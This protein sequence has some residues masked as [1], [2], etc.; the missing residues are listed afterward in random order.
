MP[1]I[2]ILSWRPTTISMLSPVSYSVGQTC[3]QLGALLSTLRER[4]AEDQ[5]ISAS[6][7]ARLLH[8]SLPWLLLIIL[9]Q[10]GQ[11][12]IVLIK[13]LSKCLFNNASRKSVV[14]DKK[15]II[16]RITFILSKMYFMYHF[17]Y[18][19]ILSYTVQYR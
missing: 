3:C 8:S 10:M 6:T 18:Q 9:G 19:I 2:D 7:G 13:D 14:Q 16:L 12:Y 5:K 1:H 11:D 4:L 17:S 15:L